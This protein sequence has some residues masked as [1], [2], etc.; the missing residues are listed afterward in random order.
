MYMYVY[1]RVCIL[2]GLHINYNASKNIFHVSQIFFLIK[3]FIL[4]CV[5]QIHINSLSSCDMQTYTAYVTWLTEFCNY[6]RSS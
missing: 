3:C 5:M 1:V 2:V 6:Y 4:S